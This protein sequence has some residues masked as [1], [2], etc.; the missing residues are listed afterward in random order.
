M[1]FTVSP[2]DFVSYS[3]SSTVWSKLKVE[4]VTR[5]VN[6]SSNEYGELF[7]MN[8]LEGVVFTV[9]DT[10][11]VFEN[12]APVDASS[13]LSKRNGQPMRVSTGTGQYV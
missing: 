10:T 12:V 5:H 13:F 7:N 6:V 4:K 2:E 3:K 1:S 8:A 11:L 9:Q